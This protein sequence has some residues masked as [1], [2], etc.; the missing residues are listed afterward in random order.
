[1]GDRWTSWEGWPD[2]IQNDD[3]AGWRSYDL[4]L[5]EYDSSLTKQPPIDPKVIGQLG[6]FLDQHQS[7]YQTT[8]LIGHSQGG[9]VIKLYIL[10]MLRRGRGADL[11]TD[12]VITL[13]TPHR[14][15][16]AASFVPLRQ[17]WQLG[18]WS[19]NIRRLARDW[20]PPYISSTPE[21][22]TGSSR[23]IRSIAVYGVFDR[24]VSRESARGFAVDI[25]EPAGAQHST[26]AKAGIRTHPVVSLILGEL[27]EHARPDAII[28]NL[29]V[30]R[31]DDT[32][33]A[34]YVAEH[35]GAIAALVAGAHPEFSQDL[36]TSKVVSIL[37]DFLYA[38]PR[39]PLR[40]LSFDEALDTYA[41]RQLRS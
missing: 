40:K 17:V 24:V 7:K 41:R 23:Y 25:P 36:V 33:R 12:L 26:L 8:I 9:L 27:R 1:M 38:F 14:G 21:P 10:D 31:S 28:D 29:T 15:V 34:T 35:M 20:G 19:R 16:A 18:R 6:E 5:F 2:L 39:R 30:I 11:S 32:A 4:Y 22:P 37:M 3:D 13:G